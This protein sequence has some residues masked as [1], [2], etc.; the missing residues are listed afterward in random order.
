MSYT[1]KCKIRNV[2]EDY[3]NTTFVENQLLKFFKYLY[4]FFAFFKV[5][6]D[7]PP[8]KS[9]NFYPSKFCEMEME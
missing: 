7:F 5:I 2:R 4:F 8:S 3:S 6:H 1:S 9:L